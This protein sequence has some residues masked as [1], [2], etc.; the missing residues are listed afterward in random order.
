MPESPVLPWKALAPIDVTDD[1]STS[2]PLTPAYLSMLA[3]MS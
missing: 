2:L 3:G 1:G